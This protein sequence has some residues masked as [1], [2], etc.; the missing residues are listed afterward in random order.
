[1]SDKISVVVTC[2]NH[3]SYIED[4][5]RSI[6][7]QTYSNIE[8]LVFNDGSTDDSGSIIQEM[9]KESPFKETHY[10]ESANKGVVE[11]RNQALSTITGD[12]LLFVDSDNFLDAHHIASLYQALVAEEADIAY[13]Q[14]W[15]FN[16]KKVVL[17]E[18]LSYHL[19]KMLTGNIIDM[20]ALVRVSIIADTRFDVA[21]NGRSL[22]DY[23]FWLSLIINHHAKPIF[24]STTKLNYRV[25]QGSRSDH[26]NW[27]SYYRAYYYILDKYKETVPY[28]IIE[29]LKGNVQMWLESYTQTNQR[30][31]TTEQALNETQQALSETQQA[32]NET[33]QALSETQ[34]ALNDAQLLAEQEAKSAREAHAALARLYNKLPIRI[35]RKLK[36]IGRSSS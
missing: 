12:Y 27:E 15:D 17:A 20:S 36:G 9:L 6:F 14:L 31:A 34:Q 32:L 16:S 8:L 3:E 11:V 29:A 23:D 26:G 4:C 5:L 2:Y 28:D 7:E 21:L 33:Q 35:Y 22:E 10:Y 19:R 1:M 30:L 13:C 24:V 25:V 18:D